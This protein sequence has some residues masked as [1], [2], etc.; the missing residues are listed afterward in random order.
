MV[1]T[2]KLEINFSG[3]ALKDLIELQQVTG[4]KT[5][6]ELIKVALKY[7]NLLIEEKLDGWSIILERRRWFKSWQKEY[8]ELKLQ[9]GGKMR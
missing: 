5:V 8:K 9:I 1:K 7:Y 6:G 3:Q 4:E 2:K